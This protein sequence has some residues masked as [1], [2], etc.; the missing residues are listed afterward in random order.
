M[1]TSCRCTTTDVR[2]TNSKSTN[3]GV[4]LANNQCHNIQQELILSNTVTESDIYDNC[5]YTSCIN[6]EIRKTPETHSTKLKFNIDKPETSQRKTDV[7]IINNSN[8]IDDKNNDIRDHSN[9]D[10]T[11]NMY[12]NIDHYNIDQRQTHHNSLYTLADNEIQSSCDLEDLDLNSIDSSKGELVIACDNKIG[13]KTLRPRVFY[14]LYIKPN[15][16]GNGH[17][18]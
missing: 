14:A 6:G 11:D 10:L 8:E 7:N 4:E 16:N 17:L 3:Q 5:S 13:N 2:T 15:D 18:I 12:N 9:S 1:I